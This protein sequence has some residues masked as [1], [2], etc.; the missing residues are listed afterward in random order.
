MSI[1][2]LTDDVVER[3]LKCLLQDGLYYSANNMYIALRSGGYALRKCDFHRMIKDVICLEIHNT[4]PFTYEYNDVY[5]LSNLY[6]ETN[7]Y[8]SW[9]IQHPLLNILNVKVIV[10]RK[11]IDNI[12]SDFRFSYDI[13]FLK[14]IYKDN[15]KMNMIFSPSYIIEWEYFPISM[16]IYKNKLYIYM[17]EDDE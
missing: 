15:G 14:V 13:T 5:L 17:V 4:M 8:K 9:N 2:G 7:K 16:Y 3:I 1:C 6:K 10:E 11:N 12:E